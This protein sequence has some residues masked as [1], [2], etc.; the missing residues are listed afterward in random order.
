MATRSNSTK[1]AELPLFP[2]FIPHTHD[3][4]EITGTVSVVLHVDVG[5][6]FSILRVLAPGRDEF[7]MVGRGDPVSV[8]DYVAADGSWEADA[9]WGRQ[10]RAKFIRGRI[11]ETTEGIVRYISAGN[12]PGIGARAAQKLADAF[13]DRL[14]EVMDAPTTLMAGGLPEQKA[15]SLV[16]HWQMRTRHGGLLSLLY[17]HKLGS[18]LAQRIIDKYGDSTMRI[19]LSDPYRLS[20][21]VR[22]IGF[23]IA[24]RIALS[25]SLPTDSPERIAAAILH[26]IEQLSRDG[27]CAVSKSVLTA[28]VSELVSISL[29]KAESEIDR[30]LVQGDLIEEFIG[31][32]PVIYSKATH[33]CEIEVAGAIASR[34]VSNPIPSDPESLIAEA[35]AFLGLPTLHIGQK[36]AV[37]RAMINSLVVITGNPGTGKTSTMSVLLECLRRLIPDVRIALSAPTGR[38]AKRLTESTKTEASTIHRLLE[39][40]PEKRGFTRNAERPLEYDIVVVDEASMID[41]WMMRDLLRAL[42][43]NARLILVGDADQLPSVGPGNVLADCIS[44]GAVP[45]A[46]LTHI[47]RQGAGSLI[48]A[49]SQ[50]IN[51]GVVPTTAKPSRSND[52]WGVYAEKP[53]EVVDNLKRLVRDAIPQMGFDPLKDLQVLTSGHNSDTGTVSLNKMLQ[54]TINPPRRGEPVL[55]H[56]EREFRLR[57][58]VI[59]IMNDYD[60]EAFNG[61]IGNV[62]S[63]TT[64]LRGEIDQMA[65]DYD[66]R[67]VVYERNEL[68]QL[69]HAY[70]ITIHKSQGSEFP[71]VICVTTTQHYIMLRRN[72][73]YTSVSRAKKLCCILG[74]RRAVARAVN[75]AGGDRMTGLAQRLASLGAAQVVLDGLAPAEDAGAQVGEQT[76]EEDADDR[77]GIDPEGADTAGISGPATDSPAKSAVEAVVEIAT[78]AAPSG[79]ERKKKGKK[80]E[81][82]L[83]LRTSLLAVMDDVDWSNQAS[84]SWRKIT[85][86]E[87]EPK[88]SGALTDFFGFEG[89]SE[90]DGKAAGKINAK[91]TMTLPETSINSN[92]H[93][94]PT[95]RRNPSSEDGVTPII[96]V[97]VL[98]DP[99]L[100]VSHSP[101]PNSPALDLAAADLPS[102]PANKTARSR[103]ALSRDSRASGSEA[104]APATAQNSQEIT[105]KPDEINSGEP[106]PSSGPGPFAN[107]EDWRNQ[108][109]DDDFAIPEE[110]WQPSSDPDIDQ[111][112]DWTRDGPGVDWDGRRDDADMPEESER[113]YDDYR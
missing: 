81:E 60:K 1:A 79:R 97:P 45:V 23:K 76:A 34:I 17:A 4:G 51:R 61:D 89:K 47:F 53:E 70:C 75:T 65:V 95:P 28:G 74:S 25:Q 113:D 111:G 105:G 5:T 46:R 85:S 31:L 108:R 49:A 67:E 93:R 100:P 26:Q 54:E 88:P 92:Q 101:M 13:G 27:H 22:G 24:D 37:L 32:R 36:R 83:D 20:R 77:T 52:M 14:P 6:G 39:W 80:P 62:V 102:I 33:D 3:P 107:D 50:Q 110:E 30:M 44:S 99:D 73:I 104:T 48:A 29:G 55:K 112:D 69:S 71:A 96:G 8:G 66:G 57:D 58:R 35:T 63:F 15:K 94:E 38:A 86:Q 91:K 68:D 98:S 109:G 41:I 11:P 103:N 9:K 56:K 64:D 10:F 106:S 78:G 16:H 18:A 90:P 7:T 19:V 87:A 72:L 84:G 59:Q 43:P 40:M 21:E 2:G 12:V 42:P 82:I